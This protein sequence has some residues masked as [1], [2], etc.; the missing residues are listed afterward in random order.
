VADLAEGQA[1]VKPKVRS[2][3]R[4]GGSS[5]T[6]LG[7]EFKKQ[8]VSLMDTLNATEPH[9]VRCM[10][11]NME[12]VG[13]V[14]DSHV[15]LGQ[16]RYAGLVEVC[17]IRQ[18][19][20]PYRMVFSKFLTLFSVLAPAGGGSPKKLLAAIVD[21]NYLAVGEFAVGTTK[22]FL[23]HVALQKLHSLRDGAL[24]GVVASIQKLMRGKLQRIRFSSM[25]KILTN[26][27]K[28]MNSSS[29]D[30]DVQLLEEALANSVELPH[31]GVHFPLVKEGKALFRKV[32]EEVK[33]KSLLEDAMKEGSVSAL[34]GAL[35]TADSVQKP[36]KVR[37]LGGVITEA[38]SVL[39]T[40]KKEKAH[41]E[42]VA[43]L[44]K[45]G[46]VEEM[47][48]WME[49][50]EELNLLKT[51]GARSIEVIIARICDERA[52]LADLAI[53]TDAKNLQMLSAL[54]S[55]VA[56][57]GLENATVAKAKKTQ[58]IL[59]SLATGMAALH[60][61]LESSHL[62]TIRDAISKA[63][64]CG[65]SFDD[66]VLKKAI[67]VADMIE[68]VHFMEEKL[69]NALNGQNIEELTALI[70]KAEQALS[71]SRDHDFDLEIAS[72]SAAISLVDSLER[73]KRVRLF[74]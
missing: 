18:L 65:V 25:K 9:F 21:K 69:K 55:K 37:E 72:L 46:N 56:E 54:L 59:E 73:Q 8:L 17:R 12:K 28:A 24:K 52:I 66:S 50:A 35:E 31:D 13:K 33:V 10:K 64:E 48:Q 53:A 39:I 61:A 2:S 67:Y 47:E 22:V 11:P 34:Q 60:T 6:T 19:G 30:V 14:F 68:N 58:H 1:I 51:E 27:Q 74:S 71:L 57:M 44:I 4:M 7:G 70:S 41:L 43:V 45:S 32:T 40:L 62:Q 23:K 20:F 49:T 36:H 42:K 29:G 63:K 15:M 16:L 26:L 5:K 38:K 3:R